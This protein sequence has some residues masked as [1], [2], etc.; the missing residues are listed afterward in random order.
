[1]GETWVLLHTRVITRG[2]LLFGPL[3]QR[4]LDGSQIALSTPSDS[5]FPAEGSRRAVSQGKLIVGPL[6]STC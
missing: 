1:M 4:P 3:D 2:R 6:G 5:G